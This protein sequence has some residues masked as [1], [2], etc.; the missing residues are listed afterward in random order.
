MELI[1]AY[2]RYDVAS[3]RFGAEQNRYSSTIQHLL[4]RVSERE[5]DEEIDGVRSEEKGTAIL[6]MGVSQPWSHMNPV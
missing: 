6:V 2:E 4:R 5:P 3:A 1:A